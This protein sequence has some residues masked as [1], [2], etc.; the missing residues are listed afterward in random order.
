MNAVIYVTVCHTSR[1][2]CITLWQNT[3]VYSIE[4]AVTQTTDPALFKAHHKC[5]TVSMVM[6]LAQTDLLT[7]EST[8]FLNSGVEV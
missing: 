3:C 7:H 4:T 5:F 1:F 6:Q 8:Q 2:W